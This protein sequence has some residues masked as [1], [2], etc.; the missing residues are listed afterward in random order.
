MRRPPAWSGGL[1]A[2]RT[3]PIVPSPHRSG[4]TLHSII[5]VGRGAVSANL[6]PEQGRSTP[7]LFGLDGEEKVVNEHSSDS[8]VCTGAV[9]CALVGP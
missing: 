6:E 7:H 5:E 1:P 8:V 2:E 3:V 4:G 9:R